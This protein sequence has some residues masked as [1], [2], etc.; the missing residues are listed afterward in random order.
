[1]GFVGCHRSSA[2]PQRMT[3]RAAFA[4][5]NTS[6]SLYRVLRVQETASPTEIKTAYRTLAKRFHPDAGSDGR[7]FMEIK[8]AYDT[9]SD[10]AA[11]VAYDRSR[12]GGA[13]LAGT[14]LRYGRRWETDQCW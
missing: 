2:S 3:I 10:P 13:R 14:G 8:E 9:L 11:R 4:P 5:A 12:A 1:M 7:D 6:T